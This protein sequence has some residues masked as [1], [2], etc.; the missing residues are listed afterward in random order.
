MKLFSSYTLG[1][2]KIAIFINLSTVEGLPDFKY[3]ESTL[4]NNS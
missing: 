2:D 4:V 3:L 1:A